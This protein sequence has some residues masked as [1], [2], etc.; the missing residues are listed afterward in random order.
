M[1]FLT[2]SQKQL[3]T[4]MLVLLMIWMMTILNHSLWFHPKEEE[5]VELRR[6]LQGNG[7]MKGGCSHM[8]S[9]V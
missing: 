5:R 8:S 4:W 6:G 9:Y 7:M 2:G 3:K 1:M